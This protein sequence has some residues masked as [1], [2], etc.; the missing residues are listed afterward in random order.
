MPMSNADEA[1]FREFFAATGPALRRTA[2]LIVRDWQLAEDL[3]QQ[4]MAKV[5]SK[6]GRIRLEARRSYAR[7]VAVNECL[8]YLRRN[9]PEVPVETV[10][11]RAVPEATSSSIDLESL[12]AILPAQQRAIL[13][14]R[15]IE[16]LS[17]NA[18]ADVLGIAPGTVK[19]QTFRATA[20]LRAHLQLTDTEDSS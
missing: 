9:R 11:D 20:A 8:T 14:L 10:P 12:L 18:T 6:W 13:A 15:F 16:D 17:I 4:A 2:Y 19:S 3:I 7:Q 1:D 5:Y